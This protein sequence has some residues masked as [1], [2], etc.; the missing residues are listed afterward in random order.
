[1]EM[2][3]FLG[4]QL[5]YLLLPNALFPPQSAQGLLPCCNPEK[6]PDCD[7]KLSAFNPKLY[8]YD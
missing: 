2:P 7:R 1:M 8:S 4:G 5:I 6:I 3:L